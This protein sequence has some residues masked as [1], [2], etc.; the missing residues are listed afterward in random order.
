MK[1]N[2]KNKL[3][4]FGIFLVSF[5]V[6]QLAIKKTL[7][8]R[9]LYKDLESKSSLCENYGYLES[10]LTRKNRS[11]NQLLEKYNFT[12]KQNFNEQNYLLEQ[13]AEKTELLDLKIIAFE[14]PQ[15]VVK[16]NNSV[17]HFS[18]SVMGNF[19]NALKLINE[20]DNNP[21]IGNIVSV[22]TSKTM[23]YK[24]IREEIITKITIEKKRI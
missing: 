19:T 4:L 23:N 3:L 20:I 9:A 16:E 14:E 17:T 15:K 1:L 10:E 24:N 18:F 11:L 5:L 6:Y 22:M 2:I 21:I 8:Y 12:T 7:E 13:L